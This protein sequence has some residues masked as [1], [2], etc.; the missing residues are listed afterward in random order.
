MKIDPWAMEAH[1][2]LARIQKE[3]GQEKPAEKRAAE[4]QIICV[5]GSTFDVGR[6]PDR[7]CAMHVVFDLRSLDARGFKPCPRCAAILDQSR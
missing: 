4:K 2:L 5:V 1:V 6:C 3:R 7:K